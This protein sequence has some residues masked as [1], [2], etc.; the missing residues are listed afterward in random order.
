MTKCPCW[1]GRQRRPPH[2]RRA[3]IVVRAGCARLRHTRVGELEARGPL[4][5]RIDLRKANDTRAREAIGQKVPEVRRFCRRVLPARRKAADP[6]GEV[7]KGDVNFVAAHGGTVVLND[8]WLV[9]GTRASAGD[10]WRR[11]RPGRRIIPALVLVQNDL[12]DHEADPELPFVDGVGARDCDSRLAKRGV[13][14]ADGTDKAVVDEE[15]HG[16]LV[17][18][19][20]GQTMREPLIRQGRQLQL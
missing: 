16:H 2:M 10:G 8:P 9:R 5:R 7:V 17:D 11:V 4:A 3:A 1:R 19:G 14:P 12:C 18:R 20:L 15:S 6:G 13:A